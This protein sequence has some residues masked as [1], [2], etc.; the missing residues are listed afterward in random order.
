MY[1]YYLGAF[2]NKSFIRPQYEIMLDGSL[3]E[4]GDNRWTEFPNGGTVSLSNSYEG[5][6]DDIRNRLLR[7]RIDFK[8]SFHPN[9][10]QFNNNSNK[11]QIS[12]NDVDDFDREEVIEI[13]DIDY[14]INEFLND[15]TKR[16]IRIKH[17]PNKLILLKYAQDCY[18]PFEFMISDIEDSYGDEAIYTLK[19]FVNSGIINRYR[20][21]DLES[22]IMDGNYSIRRT[23]KMQFIYKMEKLHE[24]EPTEQID[25]IDNEELADFFKD[26]LDKSEG[27]EN[28]AELREQFM[29]IA[30]SF[31][32]RGQLS[33]FRVK[34][35]CE[36][37]Q[38]SVELSDY[39]LRLMEEYFRNNPN[40]VADKEEYL[41][42]HSELLDE[43]ARQ[44]VQY[45]AKI[46]AI[47]IEL[48]EVEAKRDAIVREI[49]D[50]QSRLNEQQ[51][52]LEKLGEQAIAQKQ[53][54]L[55]NLLAA[56]KKELSDTETAIAKAKSERDQME[57]DRDTWKRACESAQD[58][59]KKATNNLNAM[60]VEWAANNRNTEI[61][62]LLV[63]QLE[64]PDEIET[65]EE[66]VIEIANLSDD[67]SA[68]Q[69][70][71]ILLKKMNE[72]GRNINKDDAYNYLI[73]VFQNYI[74]VFAGE[75]GTGKTSLCKLLAK[76]L[77]LYDN[78]FAE[79]L[80]ERGWTSSKD[81][82]GYYNPLTKEIEETQPAF[83]NCMKQLTR[84]NRENAVKAPYFVLLDE[85]NLSPIEYY[86][87]HF[88]YFADDPNKQRI[89]YSDGTVYS[90]GS[91]LRFLATI[92]YDQTTADLSPRFL[93]R[94]WVISMG[95]VPI[96][97]IVSS[98]TNDTMVS[99]GDEVISLE[100]LYRLF[101]WK[102][103]K[104]KKMNQITKTR[105]DRIIDKMKEGNHIISPRS[106][107]AITHYYL[108]AEGY[109]SSKEVALDFAISQK[110]L[111]CINGN[112][113]QYGEF[114]KDLMN[115]CK[116]NQLNKSANIIAKIIE[117]SEHEFYGFFN[118]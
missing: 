59:Y 84:E 3:R 60:I 2:G 24:I 19:I 102:N 58:D 113:K 101:D 54:D 18:G 13:I 5:A 23:D 67:L 11:Y 62:K 95:A 90:F 87:S 49:E 48:H 80:V 73:S 78:R 68:E 108:V 93:D 50:G 34:K 32:E 1:Q 79:I 74:T 56:K 92:N 66:K 105:L 28:L 22:I 17:K 55:E 77:G 36:L 33:D 104:D 38:M 107:H 27:I 98:L 115:I 35:I 29:Q 96:D 4:V 63:S 57:S 10:D 51:K 86:W 65:K 118:L 41:R 69:V 53:Q 15:N 88:N 91:E 72:A 110:I 39:K 37:L 71:S 111:P 94:A 61:V 83:S 21:F 82:I 117:R 45:D 14:P 97:A 75:P 7:F 81:L 109:M 44:D 6:T 30:D 16:L 106:I 70:V 8:S 20:M 116:E 85:A 43:I 42:T 52:E 31:S 64:M 114:L 9:F 26:L 25:Y 12:L 99:N 103:V 40:S 89:T 112:G 100:V 47:T 46:Q 76:S